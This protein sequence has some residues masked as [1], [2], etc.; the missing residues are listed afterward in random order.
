MKKSFFKTLLLI[1]GL[2]SVTISFGQEMTSDT[3]MR[4]RVPGRFIQF[5]LPSG[6]VRLKPF[7]GNSIAVDVGGLKNKVD[8][9]QY[10]TDI[11]SLTSTL[12]GK[13]SNSDLLS[14]SS[15]Y[16]T[17]TASL[18]ADIVTRLRSI[19]TP[20]LF[21]IAI[22]PAILYDASL[23]IRKAGTKTANSSTVIAGP[24]G[25]YYERQ[26]EG[27]V[28][29]KW[30]GAKGDGLGDDYP[31][32]ASAIDF[33]KTR[34]SISGI[35]QMSGTV[36]APPGLYPLGQRLVL[37]NK[38]RLLGEGSR[39]T[40]LY[41]TASFTDTILV[42]L[43]NKN[44]GGKVNTF[45][46]LLEHV[47]LDM[48]SRPGLIGVY[49]EEVNE[50][51]GVKSFLIRNLRYKGI[52]FKATTEFVGVGPQNFYIQEGE[53]IFDG[54]ETAESKG[55]QIDINSGDFQ[56]MRD[57]SIVGKNSLCWGIDISSAAGFAAS[58][59]H[60]ENVAR[61]FALAERGPVFAFTINGINVQNYCGASVYIRGAIADSYGYTLSG[62]R[63]AAA[64]QA[65]QD[66]RNQPTGKSN[67]PGPLGYYAVGREPYTTVLTRSVISTSTTHE[68]RYVRSESREPTAA[69]FD[70]GQV[71]VWFNSIAN[72]VKT[73]VNVNGTIK[74]SPAYN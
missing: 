29:V 67:I 8:K 10:L 38:V 15:A 12:S 62:I 16:G 22:E 20:G 70:P 51:S 21:S 3:N 17:T 55:I 19:I 45:T 33:V 63:S 26:Y 13:S 72:T 37:P 73:Y 58:S 31:A 52:Q 59:I 41:P 68:R 46:N 39:V 14:L 1:A 42:E 60:F 2:L 35:G 6:E 32:F 49:S 11:A 23:W 50:Q 25:Y 71:L 47:S 5:R 57:I 36:Y 7:W 27:F 40:E 18:S 69:D 28:N 30:F 61:G 34:K 48:R 56:S 64:G 54:N 74:A 66:F 65:V 4:P 44:Y 53:I 9:T 43:S 24:T